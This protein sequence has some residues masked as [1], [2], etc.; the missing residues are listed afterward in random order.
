LLANKGPLN[1]W[2]RHLRHSLEDPRGAGRLAWKGG[3]QRCEPGTPESA[4]TTISEDLYIAKPWRGQDIARRLIE[5]VY[6]F[7]DESGAASVYW[8]TQE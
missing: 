1:C 2:L 4:Q 6:A 3:R 8:L 5:A 7:A